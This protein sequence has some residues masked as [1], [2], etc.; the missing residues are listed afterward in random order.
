MKKNI[1]IAE[2]M[3]HLEWHVVIN[4]TYPYPINYRGSRICTENV[5][6][7]RYMQD[8]IKVTRDMFTGQFIS[9]IYLDY[10]DECMLYGITPKEQDEWKK[11]RDM[12]DARI[13]DRVN[14][15]MAKHQLILD[16]SDDLHLQSY[17]LYN[18][19]DIT[20]GEPS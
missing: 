18:V 10:R 19:I 14:K 8:L 13:K 3:L 2:P 7:S 9:S 12:M 15:E 16:F 20:E 11:D 4:T 17:D 5:Q 1:K 6:P